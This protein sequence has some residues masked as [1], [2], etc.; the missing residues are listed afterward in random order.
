MKRFPAYT[1][2][3][4][5]VIIAIISFLMGFGFTAYTKS[6]N[7][8]IGQAATEQILSLLRENQKNANIGDKDCSGQYLG[9]QVILATP[10]IL[11]SQSL[12]LN[13]SGV[14]TNTPIPG[15]IIA[16]NSLQT[17]IFQPLSSGITLSSTDPFDLDFSNSNSIYRIRIYSSGIIEYQGIQ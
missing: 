17:I 6:R 16:N 4:L 8:Q 13:D 1:L 7:R 2:I 5:M 3:E 15:I 14:E 10:N 11:S 9:Q 12:C